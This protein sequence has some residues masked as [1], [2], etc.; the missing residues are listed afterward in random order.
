MTFLTY[1]GN[2]PIL[3]MIMTLSRTFLLLGLGLLAG[4]ALS[5]SAPDKAEPPQET[6]T[7]RQDFLPRRKYVPLP[8]KAVGLLVGQIRDV[9]G[10]EGRSGPEDAVCFARSAASY[11]WV[12]LP[13]PAPAP[14]RDLRVPVGEKGT[15]FQVYTALDIARPAMLA[16]WG[17]RTLPALVEVEVNG[18]RGSPAG[19]SFVATHLRL[20]EGS[21]EYPLPASKILADLRQ[22]Y[23]RFLKERHKDLEAALK[24]AQQQ[25]LGDGKPTGPREQKEL[26]YFTWL[27]ETNALQARFLTR[28][29]DGA[30]HYVRGGA[31]P[32]PGVP[33]PAG[34]LRVGTT[35]GVEVG[36][37]YEVSATGQLR[38][39]A[40]LPITTFVQRLPLPP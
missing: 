10:Q 31:R 36:M 22:R 40:L 8:G 34:Q 2:T 26:G 35:F 5:D 21:Q 32:G 19:E 39:Q 6:W 16:G 11:R 24:T 1:P 9:V 13:V 4:S 28:W 17:I 15:E 12:Y 33:P 29:T 3:E 23:Q 25:A 37:L 27:P 20:L 38:R 18:G 30:Y 14:I 7:A